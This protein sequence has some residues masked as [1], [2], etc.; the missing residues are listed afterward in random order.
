MEKLNNLYKWL[1][2]EGVSIFERPLPFSNPDTKSASIRLNMTG[3]WGM[4]IDRSRLEDSTEE[5]SAIAHEC[6]HFATGT[7]HQVCSPLDLIEKHEYKADKWAV[8]HLVSEEKLDNAV[9]DGY[10]EIWSLAEYFGTTEDMMKKAVCWY[11]YG[12]LD[13][14]L[15]F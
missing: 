5:L 14:E 9:A 4:F 12:N 15:Y 7:T 1:D 2:E 11:V 6:G 8:Q 10:T 3:E 13:T